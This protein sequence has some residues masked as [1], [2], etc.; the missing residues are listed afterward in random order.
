[1]QGAL[2][3]RET[4]QSL[5]TRGMSTS[6]KLWITEKKERDMKLWGIQEELWIIQNK[7][8]DF[9]SFLKEHPGGKRWL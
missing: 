6:T 2:K 4:K 7:V 5:P 3:I 1:M 9:T 8:Y